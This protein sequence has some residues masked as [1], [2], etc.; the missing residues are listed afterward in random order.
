MSRISRRPR[1]QGKEC[2]EPHMDAKGKQNSSD[3]SQHFKF[4]SFVLDTLA[5]AAISHCCCISSCS[6]LRH[7]GARPME[8]EKRPRDCFTVVKLLH[9]HS[10]SM[11]RKHSA[12]GRQRIVIDRTDSGYHESL[13]GSYSLPV[14]RILVRRRASRVP[15]RNVGYGYLIS[16]HLVS[17]L[18]K[19]LAFTDSRD[20]A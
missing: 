17:T 18:M 16:C 15:P 4:P 13:C 20:P 1:R 2:P 19:N 12:C 6:C 10:V 5:Y 3:H 8:I 11:G 7:P 14:D 9:V